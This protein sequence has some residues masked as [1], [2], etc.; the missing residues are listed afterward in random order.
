MSAALKAVELTPEAMAF[1]KEGTGNLE[2]PT[3]AP[4]PSKPIETMP[5]PEPLEPVPERPV[6]SPKINRSR[7]TVQRPDVGSPS[8]G[9]VG[10]SFRLPE[11]LHMALMQASF[12]RKMNRQKPWTQQEMVADALTGWLKKQGYL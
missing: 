2:R 6:E 5:A 12:D 11:H 7:I 3:L 10:L 9:V 4:A 8:A 1:I